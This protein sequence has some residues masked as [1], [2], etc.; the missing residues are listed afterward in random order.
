MTLADL[1]IV[2]LGASVA[3]ALAKS[4]AGEGFAKEVLP[5]LFGPLEDWAK[6]KAES[7]AAEKELAKV[8]QIV[9]EKMQRRMSTRFGLLDESRKRAVVREAVTTLAKVE[10]NADLV[11]KF[12]LKEERLCRHLLS[13]RPHISEDFS[14][15][16]ATLYEELLREASLHILK[17]ATQLTGFTGSAF[18]EVLEGQDKLLGLLERM[19]GDA[20]EEW[21]KFEAR[22]RESVKERFDRMDLFG[23]SRVD[24]L[25]RSQSL[26]VSYIT[27]QVERY[28]ARKPKRASAP[29]AQDGMQ[30]ALAQE[31]LRPG[32]IDKMLMK[33]R[34]L[35][36]RG[37]AG[38]GKTT[39]L[40]W[41]AVRSAAQDFPQDLA[42]WNT[43]VPFFIRLRER[44]GQGF[45]A[46]E[47]LPGLVAPMVAG[48][49]PSPR[50]VHELLDK[51]N[52]LVLVDGVDELPKEQREQMRMGLAQMVV[53]YPLARYVV[54][55]R[56]S[57][58]NADDFPE[59]RRWIAEAKFTEVA[60]QPMEL[61]HMYSFIDRWHDAVRE[62]IDPSEAEK[63]ARLPDN[64][65]VKLRLRPE[66]RR[67]AKSP[68]LCAMI[69]ALHRE[70]E[71]I[72]P[73]DRLTL[74]GDCCEMLM[75]LRE[76]VRRVAAVADYPPMESPQ[77][78][79]LMRSFAYYLMQNGWSDVEAELA[80][81][82][83]ERRL[84]L[85]V[86][87]GATGEKVRKYFVERTNLLREPV[88]GR[89]DF[90]HRTFQEFLAA[91][92]AID[93]GDIGVLINNAHDDQWRETIIL[94]AGHAS[95]RECE[96]LLKGIIQR[97]NETL[98][99]RVFRSRK[100]KEL[101]YKLHL[102]ALAC[103]ETP[104]QLAPAVREYVVE[105]AAAL[106]P[107]KNSDEAKMIAGAG[108]PAV[109]FMLP[110]PSYS[111]E[112][113]AACVKALSLIGWG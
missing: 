8:G 74:Y 75:T 94:A 107:P 70:R 81:T 22:Y 13:F 78:Q 53:A 27:L 17:I 69:C 33:S 108:D 68:L 4:F 46:P 52:A 19:A 7:R 63:F 88:E 29:P 34:R 80:D 100:A 58:L 39:L 10:I 40:H 50:W 23:V 113:A 96:M 85:M 37:D 76:G 84:K 9:A 12:N 99:E 56:P 60:L 21:V 71:D 28:T 2:R 26:T 20:E 89:I 62:L 82:H 83:F 65:K 57:A 15:E 54:S 30:N 41:I 3:K 32:P 93:D 5:E 55:S 95:Q 51:G 11:L 1:L 112:V 31:E 73:S 61:P 43:T 67:L 35:V 87:P 72:L 18:A 98:L 106:L 92:Q 47:E 111:D 101:R 97:G 42:D 90:T 105:Q 24:K 102:L 79:A 104:V 45:P 44:V 25:Q 59:W 38:S 91:R 64:L 16:E 103:L 36:V 109:E 86:V 77:K 14:T 49:T 48:G 6:G 110:R 66:L